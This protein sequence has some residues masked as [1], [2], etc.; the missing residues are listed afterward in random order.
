MVGLHV[1]VMAIC[2]VMIYKVLDFHGFKIAEAGIIFSLACLL[3][4]ISTEVYGYKLGGRLIWIALICQ[5]IF[6]LCV[7][8]GSI[9]Q[10]NENS[11]SQQYFS[12]FH[13]LW[14]VLIGTWVSVLVSYFCN[15]F[16]VSKLKIYFKGKL[17]IVRYS[18]SSVISQGLLLFIAYPIHLSSKYDMHDLINII[19]TTW[20]YKV[21][22]SVVLLPVGV[23]LVRFVKKVEKTDYYDWQV[24]YSPFQVF[25]ESGGEIDRNRF[26]KSK[27]C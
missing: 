20:S 22:M 15:S 27:Q 2:G 21:I 14:R 24:S 7:Y 19:L 26:N 1:T 16:I 3:S 8:I 13:Q 18:V 4:T 5:T 9:I 11:I 23:F 17:F 10:R 12:L 25:Q 6:L